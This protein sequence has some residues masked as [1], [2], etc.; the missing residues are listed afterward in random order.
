MASVRTV[1]LT[2]AIWRG[3]CE[4]GILTVA[5]TGPSQA[6][7]QTHPHTFLTPKKSS[8]L[9]TQIRGISRRGVYQVINGHEAGA[10]TK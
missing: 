2:V 5:L 10:W 4:D 1:V 3:G 8:D 6:S 9:H 7:S